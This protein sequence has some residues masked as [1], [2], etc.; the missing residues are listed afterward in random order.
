[1]TCK[2][3]L[4]VSNSWESEITVQGTRMEPLDLVHFYNTIVTSTLSYCV[5]VMVPDSKSLSI[6]SLFILMVVEHTAP[7]G[8]VDTELKPALTMSSIAIVSEPVSTA[9]DEVY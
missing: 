2:V 4:L 3:Y 7:L 6:F 8:R 1:M 5:A 9:T